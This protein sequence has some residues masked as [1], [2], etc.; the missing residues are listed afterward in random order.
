MDVTSLPVNPHVTT[1]IPTNTFDLIWIVSTALI[2]ILLAIIAMFLKR[3]I[4]KMD[5]M[6]DNISNL[7]TDEAVTK[8]ELKSHIENGGVHCSGTDC[9]YHRRVTDVQV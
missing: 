1:M 8:S 6:G 3:L 4:D 9:M 7:L 2:L 5:K